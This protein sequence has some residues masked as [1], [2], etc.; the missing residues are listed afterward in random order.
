MNEQKFSKPL[1]A[2]SHQCLHQN[3]N[4]LSRHLLKDVEIPKILPACKR[5]LITSPAKHHSHSEPTSSHH[6]QMV[7]LSTS[8][9][10]Y[11]PAA[12]L[13]ILNHSRWYEPLTTVAGLPLIK[14]FNIFNHELSIMIYHHEEAFWMTIISNWFSIQQSSKTTN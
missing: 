2:H 5:Q 6:K 14:S 3:K 8:M 9:N 10:P 1:Q 4:C 13:S 7:L 12:P 11:R